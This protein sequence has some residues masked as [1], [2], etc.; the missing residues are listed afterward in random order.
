MKCNFLKIDAIAFD[1]LWKYDV[2]RHYAATPAVPASTWT[3]SVADPNTDL[4]IPRERCCLFPQKCVCITLP[5][6]AWHE[7]RQTDRRAPSPWRIFAHETKRSDDEAPSLIA[8]SSYAMTC[9]KLVPVEKFGNA[10][11]RLFVP[12]GFL[13]DWL[14]L[15]WRRPK[16]EKSVSRIQP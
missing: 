6:L 15:A 3:T 8:E 2:S 12:N 13:T 14:L 11:S 10:G 5:W 16:G 7:S 1:H 9:V 4:K